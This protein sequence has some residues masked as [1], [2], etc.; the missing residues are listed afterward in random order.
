MI[1]T[2]IF[3]Y[4]IK[5][6]QGIQLQTA[7]VTPKGFV[8]DREFM[9]VNSQGRF[10]TQRQYPD[11]ARIKVTISADLIDLEV[12]N[13]SFPPLQF[14]PTV[15]GKEL[16][17]MVWR[18]RTFAIDQGDHVADWFTQA[19]QL[20]SEKQVRLVRQS[21]NH[22][23][24]INPKYAAK[25][26]EPVSFADGYPFLLTA[27]GSLAELN[28]RIDEFPDQSQAVSMNRFRPNIVVNTTEPFIE[29]KW[30]L[31]KI[32]EVQFSVVKPCSRC[33]ITTTE[34]NTGKRDSFK[35]PLRT[36]GTFRQFGNEGVMF[37]ENM[38]PR[39]IGSIHVGDSVQVLQLKPRM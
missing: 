16:P 5:S 23:R 28:S 35:E 24:P 21:P 31:I 32:G 14:S 12:N 22:I 37:G 26:D 10:I 18:D 20:P 19:L 38:I 1:V 11:L 4:P 34:Q 17:V 2:D 15:T 39:S 27:T 36:L 30:N 6:C 13:S 29:E 9:L 8:W 33:I 3:I 7:E 25:P